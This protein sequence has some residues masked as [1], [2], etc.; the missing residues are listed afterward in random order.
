MNL[1][2]YSIRLRELSD[3]YANQRIMLDEYRLQRKA[4]LDKIDEIVN[5]QTAVAEE[6]SEQD[7]GKE[8]LTGILD[9]VIGV[10]RK[11]EDPDAP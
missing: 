3:D 8:K 10:L 4:I 2:E 9:K 1:S 5:G 11:P 7:Q 6:Q